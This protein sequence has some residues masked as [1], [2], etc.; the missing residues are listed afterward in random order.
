M[1]L[2]EKVQTILENHRIGI[3]STIRD[4]KP[5]SCFMIFQHDGYTLYIGANEETQKI[6]D[7]RNNEHVHVLLGY[8]GKGW[9]DN[10]LEIEAT[11]TLVEDENQ[12][13]KYWSEELTKWVQ[14]PSDPNY[15]LVK[16][17]PST[18]AYIENAGSEP[19]VLTL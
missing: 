3:L 13:Q 18:I 5:H 8:E 17:T 15:I 7:I 9:N 4:G 1:S 19:E 16:I 14:D 6:G 12:K 11:A 10:F 2:E